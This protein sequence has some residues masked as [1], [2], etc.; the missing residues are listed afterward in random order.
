M[1]RSQRKSH[2]RFLPSPNQHLPISKFITFSLYIHDTMSLLLIQSQRKHESF[3]N[4]DRSFCSSDLCYSHGLLPCFGSCVG[5]SIGDRM[6]SSLLEED[7]DQGRKR[8]TETCKEEENERGAAKQV[9]P[10]SKR[11][12]SAYV[13]NDNQLKEYIYIQIDRYM[14]PHPSFFK[15]EVSVFQGSLGYV[16]NRQWNWKP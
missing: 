13:V 15:T 3:G 2:V 14:D 16:V 10:D 7:D 12:A 6:V 5:A 4:E 8:S 9:E 1:E 11:A